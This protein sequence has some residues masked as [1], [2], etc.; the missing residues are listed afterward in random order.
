MRNTLQTL[1]VIAL[2]SHAGALA[3]IAATDAPELFD[4][5]APE[6]AR[7][8]AIE[9]PQG[10]AVSDPAARI[11]NG[12]AVTVENARWVRIYLDLPAATLRA[13]SAV[14][15]VGQE[16]GGADEV[17][18]RR[19]L[20]QDTDEDN[21]T[22][23]PPQIRHPT[24]HVRAHL[25][26]AAGSARPSISIARV[27]VK[28][29]SDAD[30]APVVSIGGEAAKSV[31]V[32]D[33]KLLERY[34]DR[35]NLESVTRGAS[36]ERLQRSASVTVPD[37][38][39]DYSLSVARLHRKAPQCLIAQVD[40]ESHVFMNAETIGCTAF[41]VGSDLFATAWH[42]M[43]DNGNGQ[44]KNTRLQFG[45]KNSR[46]DG[47]ESF[48]AEERCSE[49][50]YRSARLDFVVFRIEKKRFEKWEKAPIL[51]FMTG[52]GTLPFQDE[53]LA[54]LHYPSPSSDCNVP[55]R[56]DSSGVQPGLRLSRW[57]KSTRGGLCKV[58]GKGIEGS[59]RR[60]L[61]N[62]P[63]DPRD[64]CESS[65]RRNRDLAFG[66]GC[67]TCE[68]SS[69]SPVISIA[70]DADRRGRVL[71][72][73]VNA[74][75]EEMPNR[76]VRSHAIAECLDLDALFKAGEVKAAATAGGKDYCACSGSDVCPPAAQTA[77][78][79]PSP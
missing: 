43:P 4:A 13:I 3:A 48:V 9:P 27:L 62:P 74:S 58:L 23:A 71:G 33:E 10:M 56:E 50:L 37:F 54:I 65:R 66:Y 17:I 28:P 52:A 2:F 59:G 19:D 42:C 14:E 61:L 11:W 44:C 30:A 15:I 32:E 60:Y 51:H 21:L 64:V 67:A 46:D 41:R 38:L 34:A 1:L 8:L 75:H 76:A 26:D 63:K 20:T 40:R 49:I 16:T 57:S 79:T 77:T 39:F 5:V 73:H 47:G 68:G 22:L 45:Y 35:G 29:R 69:G 70:D 72:V 18:W 78:A 55:S 24:F 6:R 12:P 25:T 7:T 36:W 31:A 53:P